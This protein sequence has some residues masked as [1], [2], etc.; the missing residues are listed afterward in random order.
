[1]N[2]VIT[3]ALDHRI[4]QRGVMETQE[5]PKM[6]GPIIVERNTKSW[7]QCYQDF[8]NMKP[9]SFTEKVGATESHQWCTKVDRILAQFDCSGNYKHRMA[10]FLL[11]GNAATWWELMGRTVDA[12]EVTWTR[13][14]DLFHEHFFPSAQCQAMNRQF[15]VLEQ[16]EN[17]LVVEYECEFDHLS[18]FAAHLMP[19]EEDKIERFLS[20]LH[21][22]I[23]RR[24]IGNPSFDSYAV[25]HKR[26]Q[27]ARKK[28]V[29]HKGNERPNEGGRNSWKKPR[30]DEKTT[31]HS[32]ATQAPQLLRI[33]EE[34]KPYVFRGQCYKCGEQGKKSLDCPN[35]NKPGVVNNVKGREVPL[36]RDQTRMN[37]ML[38]RGSGEH[39][40]QME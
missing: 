7:V 35:K 25:E 31:N 4:G 21:N 33:M 16:K 18:I 20:G 19:T 5:P 38:P 24:I 14:K 9:P 11:D 13:F 30:A 23:A 26:I 1:M 36:G 40:F 6:S 15:E 2:N 34:E 39:V 8:Q 29:E 10:A 3:A 22:G 17:Q 32:E 12:M 28:K 27:E 37:V